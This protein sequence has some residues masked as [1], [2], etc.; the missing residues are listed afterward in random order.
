MQVIMDKA[1]SLGKSTHNLRPAVIRLIGHGVSVRV[2]AGSDLTAT[3]AAAGRSAGRAQ[4]RA[5]I[6]HA[7]ILW[8][9]NAFMCGSCNWTVSSQANVERVV[10]MR[11]GVVG[12]AWIAQDFLTLWAG[13]TD[14][15]EAEIERAPG[16]A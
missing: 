16:G 6:L 1:Q 14:F 9:E 4:G 10:V 3:Y 15:V 13:A 11:P 8:T 12:T 5:G 7:K 2:I